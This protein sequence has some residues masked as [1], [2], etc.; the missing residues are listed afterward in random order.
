M[1]VHLDRRVTIERRTVAKDS[2][3]G[4]AVETWTVL[5]VAW[6][7]RQ[8]ALPSRQESLQQGVE[9]SRVPIRY[10]LRYRS[11]VDSTMRVRD[12]SQ[13]L[14]IVGGP[15]EIG[16]GRREWMELACEEFKPA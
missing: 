14:Q 1:I 4:S 2:T 15:T 7:E 16:P 8:D 6:V 3:Y 11:D 5:A 13:L 9:R 12:G 10:R